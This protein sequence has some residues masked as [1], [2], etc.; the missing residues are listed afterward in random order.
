MEEDNQIE[1]GGGRKWGII[2]IVVAVIA[3]VGIFVFLYSGESVDVV[4]EEVVAED[5][6]SEEVVAEDIRTFHVKTSPWDPYMYEEDGEYKGIAYD[7]LDLVMTRLDVDYDFELIPWSRAMKMSGAGEVDALLSG[8]YSKAREEFTTFT[9][10]QL[11]YG[12]NGIA[13]THYLHT[14]EGSFWVRNVFIDSFVFESIDQIKADGYRIGMNQGYSYG[15]EVNN[16][17][18]NVV[19]H[20]TEEESMEALAKGDIDMFLTP[21]PVGFVTRRKLGLQDEI[22]IAKGPVPYVAYQFLLFSKYS[23]YPDIGELQRLVD[24]EFLK[25]HESG[26]YDEIYARYTQ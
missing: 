17:D 19:Y 21:E 16:A 2:G 4:S 15:T 9:P 7:V 3:V 6:V 24:E 25:I 13:P 20:V 18:W 12:Y 14:V 22:S 8:T 11:D 10:E 23:D 26:E 5:V 1:D